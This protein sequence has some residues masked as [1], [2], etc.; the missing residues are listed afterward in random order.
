MAEQDSTTAT[1]TG[2]SGVS[3]ERMPL[4]P[5]REAF[6][7]GYVFRFLEYW[8][9][10]RVPSRFLLGL[11]AGII[12]IV[13]VLFFFQLK[14][15]DQRRIVRDY[16]QAVAEAIEN[17]EWNSAAL[18]LRS[19]C[20][21]QPSVRSYK[22]QLAL[23][24]QRLD[25]ESGAVGLMHQ[26]AP[27]DGTN[28]Y[29]PA[30]IWLVRQ[31]LSGKIPDISADEIGQRLQAA[32]KTRPSDPEAHK[33][34]ADY[35][36]SQKQFRLAETHLRKGAE[37]DPE[38]YLSLAQLQKQ[39]KRDPELVQQG[40]EAASI[41]FQGRLS[42]D[43]TDVAARIHWAQCHS[44]ERQFKEAELILREGLSLKDSPELRHAL[45]QLYVEVA[46]IKMQDSPLNVTLGRRLLVQS[47]AITPANSVVITQLS[48]LPE[49][50]LTVSVK[51]LEV[52]LNYW[53]AQ[54]RREDNSLAR[55]AVAQL[56]E[57][58]GKV[59]EA[60]QHLESGLTQYPESRSLL[61]QLYA[62]ADRKEESDRLYDQLLDELNELQDQPQSRIAYGRA[63]L[64]FQAKRLDEAIT[65]IRLDHE[66]IPDSERTA[67]DR[68]R[69]QI[70]VALADGLLSRSVDASGEALELLK[71]AVS[72]VPQDQQVL[73][74]IAK[75]SCSNLSVAEEAD[76]LLVRIL[77]E[78]SSNSTVYNFIGTEALRENQFE[79]A[80]RNLETARRLTPRNPM[81]L[82]NLALAVLRGPSPD[83]DYSL[84][85]VETVLQL[86]PENPD[87]LGSRA[88][89]LMAMDRL[90]EADR[91]LQVALPD[92]PSS[93]QLRRLLISVN[94][95]LGN[96][97]LADEHRQILN[98]MQDQKD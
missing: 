49:T 34:L 64:L 36:L 66:G 48:R 10:S 68:L 1:R 30:Q 8:F 15:N 42:E 21:L 37:Q 65:A 88:E 72:V 79:K 3:K 57:I 39:L 89:I 41:A 51:D 84:S 96:Q 54:L 97:D 71:E 12:V 5:G 85:L 14:H 59:P 94:E 4:P 40:L 25:N 32:V 70:L 50:E 90:E 16:Q 75:I 53:R 55:I 18:F 74:R 22:F 60:I 87:A 33:F 95:R 19:L 26:L 52:P 76:E 11:P 7:V 23:L 62:Q 56:L 73:V 77:A 86:L 31:A 98:S 46:N 43:S 29:A 47:L 58:C 2:G 69:S 67:M 78:G 35:Y 13:G 24:F 83:F 38:L 17:E 61:A 27:L 6:K 80:R 93:K 9:F 20:T 63:M 91:D 92:R 45:S 44:L 28:G 81:V 82:N